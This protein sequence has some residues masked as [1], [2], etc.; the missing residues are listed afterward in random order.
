MQAEAGVMHLQDKDP[1]QPAEAAR[2]RLLQS[3][4]KKPTLPIPKES[5]PS[6]EAQQAPELQMVIFILFQTTWFV[7]NLLRKQ[8]QVGL[9]QSQLLATKENTLKINK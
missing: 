5:T 1:W 4:W 2:D 6:F 8:T 3:F 9:S 7:V